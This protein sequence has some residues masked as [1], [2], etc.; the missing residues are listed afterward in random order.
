MTAARLV[1]VAFGLMMVAASA[2]GAGGPALVAASVGAVAVLVGLFARAAA[3]VAVTSAVCAIALSDPQPLLAALAGLSAAAYLV[4][5]HTA[6]TRPTAIAMVGFTLAGLLA[7]ALPAGASWL[8]LAAP[9]A[10]VLVFAVAMH[11]FFAQ[12]G[13]AGTS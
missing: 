4:L 12:H 11:P 5:A 7:T 9:V 3:T 6:M 10:A 8:P 13:E 2:A 1:A